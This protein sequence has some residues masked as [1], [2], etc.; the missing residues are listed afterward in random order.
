MRRIGFGPKRRFRRSPRKPP[1]RS[2][3]SRKPFE[4]ARFRRRRLPRFLDRIVFCLF[5]ED[6][7]LL[8][9][10][11][12]TKVV[13]NTQPHPEQFREVIGELF[14]AMARGGTSAPKN[15]VFQ[16]RSVR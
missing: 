7:G 3:R 10:R 12:F 2:P 16:R 11:L 8:P 4:R 1:Q 9:E 13:E 6:V 15:R 14:G 5:A